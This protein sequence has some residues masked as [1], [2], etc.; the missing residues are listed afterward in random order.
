L[1]VRT[2]SF[3][4]IR[5]RQQRLEPLTGTGT[6]VAARHRA[7]R[8]ALGSG[9]GATEDHAVGSRFG[10]AE[11]GLTASRSGEERRLGAVEADRTI[12]CPPG[13]IDP[14]ENPASPSTGVSSVSGQ[15]NFIP[16]CA[17][18]HPSSHP[19]TIFNRHG[20]DEILMEGVV[21]QPRM[22]TMFS[23]KGV[24]R[25]AGL[26]AKPSYHCSIF[27]WRCD[28]AVMRPL[29]RPH[30]AKGASRTR[31]EL[32]TGS[33]KSAPRYYGDSNDQLA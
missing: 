29:Y 16:M 5:G 27:R 1:L 4:S 13:L 7:N 24:V 30:R 12:T 33:S 14:S 10:Q 22:T 20:A 21:S 6:F 8:N 23:L 15:L 9:F 3:F 32:E 11:T 17:A 31:K 19:L 2:P 28:N 25:L 26:T 18:S